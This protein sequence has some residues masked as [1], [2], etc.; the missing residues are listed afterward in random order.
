MKTRRSQYQQQRVKNL[1]LAA[2]AGQAGC[3]TLVIV[4][5][6][7]FIGLWLDS[8][9]GQRG[10]CTFGILILSVPFSLFVMLQIT[11]RA[12]ERII[13]QP[14]VNRDEPSTDS[15]KEE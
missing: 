10:P 14:T 2:V 1:A 13:P 6:A 9:L 8:Q 12:V 4:I 15:N 7:M 11:V 5:A 3:V